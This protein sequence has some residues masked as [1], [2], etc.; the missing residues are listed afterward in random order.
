MQHSPQQKL[1]LHRDVQQDSNNYDKTLNKNNINNLRP[2]RPSLS[3]AIAFLLR[4]YIYKWR[5][6]GRE[7]QR[8]QLGWS[9]TSM[10]ASS[11]VIRNSTAGG[12][13]ERASGGAE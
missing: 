9:I 3:S 12:S 6:M 8:H 10:T 5:R 13:G 4:W 1:I 11:A 7:K 2:R